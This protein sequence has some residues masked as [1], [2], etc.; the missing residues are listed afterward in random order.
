VAAAAAAAAEAWMWFEPRKQ[1]KVE[2]IALNM[3]IFQAMMVCCLDSAC[4][5]PQLSHLIHV[6]MLV[7]AAYLA[8]LQHSPCQLRYIG[9]VAI[10]K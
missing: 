5:V 1:I 8:R 3:C 6:R 10:L 4:R 9:N 2:E 7:P